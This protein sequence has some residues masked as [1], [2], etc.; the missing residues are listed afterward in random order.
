MSLLRDIS[1]EKANIAA[2]RKDTIR[3]SAMMAS[4]AR[5]KA[6]A[7]AD[8]LADAASANKAI[9]VDP[10]VLATDTGQ[11]GQIAFDT[12]Y[13]YVCVSEN[14]WLRAAIVTW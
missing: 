11:P 3:Q 5:R 2:A 6:I 8:E 13:F 14:V 9:V 1:A 4:L 12:S 7:T 10:P